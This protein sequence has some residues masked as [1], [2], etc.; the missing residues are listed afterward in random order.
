MKTR[1]FI[2]ITVMLVTLASMTACTTYDNPY[3]PALDE[4]DPEELLKGEWWLVGWNDG[5]TWFEVD[6]NYVSHQCLSIEFQ[7]FEEDIPIWAWSIVNEIYVGKLLSVNGKEL[8]LDKEGKGSTAMGCNIMESNFFEKYIFDIKSYQISGKQLRLYY[9]DEDYFVFT[10]D[11]DNSEEYKYAWKN[12]LPDRYIGEVTTMNNDEV[13]VKILDYPQYAG[14][15]ARSCPPS[16]SYDLCHFAVTDLPGASFE[17]GDKIAFRIDKFRRLKDR[18]KEY[19]CKITPYESTERVD[20]VVG[21]VYND[22]SFRGWCIMIPS[23]NEKCTATY[24]FPMKQLPETYLTENQPVIISGTLYPTWNHVSNMAHREEAQY[25]V[26]IDKL[27]KCT[28]EDVISRWAL[29]PVE[30]GDVYAVL[31][32]YFQNKYPSV[33]WSEQFFR[34]FEGDKTE[35]YKNYDEILLGKKA[36][37]PEIDLSKYTLVV[38]QAVMSKGFYSVERQEM[39]PCGTGWQLNL[40]VKK[41]EGN[42]SS[43]QYLFYWGLYPK[44]NYYKITANIVKL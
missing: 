11:F 35:M 22:Q 15:Y 4:A 30:E 33:P 25:Y 3:N 26:N 34:K 32:D 7:E 1:T 19:Q 29:S 41:A 28:A 36:E 16:S 21:L 31:S 2:G 23:N 6:T 43:T 12:G 44:K 5:G 24:Y 40:Y 27:E 42:Q 14:S 17:V 13:I 38:G 9:T 10:K 39:V 18:S 37:F 20:D 8:V